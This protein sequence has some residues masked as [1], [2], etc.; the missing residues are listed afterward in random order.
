MKAM[1]L[2]ASALLVAATA[3][4][5]GPEDLKAIGQGRGLYLRHCAACHGADARG[6]GAP[7]ATA[8][9][10]APDLT[11][12]SARDGAFDRL[13]V[14]AQVRHG[15]RGMPQ[16]GLAL[17]RVGLGRSEGAAARDIWLLA[18]YLEY[19]QT[20][21]VTTATRPAAEE[22]PEPPPGR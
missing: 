17:A 10:P 9:R 20:P 11:A 21:G 15:G 12:L 1:V 19:A 5:Y 18:R 22:R 13:H 4:A 16:W 14:S 8:A 3:S 6:G 2:G 7:A